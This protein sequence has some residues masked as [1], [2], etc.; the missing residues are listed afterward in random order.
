MYPA[1][2]LFFFIV[3]FWKINNNYIITDSSCLLFFA[4][5]EYSIE[6][7]NIYRRIYK[8]Y[9]NMAWC[10]R[11]TTRRQCKRLHFWTSHLFINAV[12]LEI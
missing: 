6:Y 10:L 11:H 5:S 1:Q 4:E 3:I 7:S 2:N 8:T 9:E 12:F